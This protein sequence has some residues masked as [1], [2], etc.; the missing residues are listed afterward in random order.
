MLGFFYLEMQN[1]CIEF[2]GCLHFL[3]QL[4]S[5]LCTLAVLQSAQF[6]V[7]AAGLEN[8]VVSGRFGVHR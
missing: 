4:S 6:G 7:T 2:S 8:R 5:P 3:M 1:F